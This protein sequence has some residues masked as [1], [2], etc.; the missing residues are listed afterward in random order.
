MAVLYKLGDWLR[1]LSRPTVQIQVRETAT[2]DALPTPLP[3]NELFLVGNSIRPKWAVLACPCG[4]GR[5]ID[6]NLMPTRR[7][8]WKLSRTGNLVSLFP[9]LW[10]PETHCGSH[11]WIIDSRI[12]WDPGLG[13]YRAPK[14]RGA[15]DDEPRTEGFDP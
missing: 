11:F 6:V 1:R 3:Q 4:C 7:P 12:H 9:S 5:R 2:M 10:M 15:R 13:R 8:T 14:A